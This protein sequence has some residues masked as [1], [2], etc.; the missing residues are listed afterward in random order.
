MKTNVSAKTQPRLMEIFFTHSGSYEVCV[1]L[2]K[3]YDNQSIAVQTDYCCL[4]NALVRYWI[5]QRKI[6]VKHETIDSI[7]FGYY[8]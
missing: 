7:L 4:L 3:K 6:E 5:L 1:E 2:S 8:P